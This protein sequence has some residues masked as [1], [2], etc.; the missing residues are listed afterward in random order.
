MGTEESGADGHGTAHRHCIRNGAGILR[1][2]FGNPA[3][4][5][6]YRYRGAFGGAPRLF[7]AEI[8]EVRQ[9]YLCDGRQSGIC[10]PDGAERP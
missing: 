8:Y 10:Y 1:G 5:P 2:L 4:H 9:K 7:N 6:S 3:V